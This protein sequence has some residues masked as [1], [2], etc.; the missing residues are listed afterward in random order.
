MSS[1]ILPYKITGAYEAFLAEFQ[2]VIED[3]DGRVVEPSAIPSCFRQSAQ[4]DSVDFEMCLRVKKCPCKKQLPRGKQLD[5]VIKA[6]E[7]L[8]KGSWSLVRSTVYVNYFLLTDST[9]RLVRAFHYDFE[10][11]GQVAH[12]LFHMQ[13]LDE[14]IP[15]PDLRSVGFEG[16]TKLPEE[17][18]ESCIG[19]R[20]PTADMTLSSVLYCLVA[21]HL[22]A[23]AFGHFAKNVRSIQDRLPTL[24]FDTLKASLEASAAHFKSSHWFAHAHAG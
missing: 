9:A 24:G 7:R 22:E 19:T 17:A 4:T 11:G 14:T 6:L 8:E 20:I 15:E 3:A 18:L 16:T 2:K 5:I 13:L 21:D 1:T 10:K 12:P 23:P